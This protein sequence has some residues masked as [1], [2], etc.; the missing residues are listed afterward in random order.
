MDPEKLAYAFHG[1]YERSGDTADMIQE[2]ADSARYWYEEVFA[3]Y[4]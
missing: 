3:D 1:S 2:R 4:N